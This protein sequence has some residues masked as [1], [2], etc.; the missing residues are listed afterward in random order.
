MLEP[1]A[2]RRVWSFP[3]SPADRLS[4]GQA[5]KEIMYQRILVTVENSSND[6]VILNHIQDLVALTG[7]RLLLV[8]VANGWV[9]RNFD[10]LKLRESEE[11][12][13]DRDYLAN[14]CENLR[15]KGI[16]TDYI[17]AYGEPSDEIIRI[18]REQQVDLIAMT[19]HGH[20]F[21]SDLLYGSVSH[22]VRHAVNI[23]VL[24]LKAK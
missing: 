22:D 3:G 23:P 5:L 20:R 24:L 8:C 7:A 10:Q 11:M 14:L 4:L 18:A 1:G 19:T 17:L 6:Q 12:R 13:R 2:E 15:E 9:A 16:E 21:I